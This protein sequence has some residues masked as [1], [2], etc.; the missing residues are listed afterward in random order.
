[1]TTSAI[2]FLY[3]STVQ[4]LMSPGPPRYFVWTPLGLGAGTTLRRLRS[5]VDQA[6]G[7][8]FYVS[9]LQGARRV[10]E[11]VKVFRERSAAAAAGDGAAPPKNFL[12]IEAVNVDFEERCQPLADLTDDDFAHGRLVVSAP[13]P[14]AVELERDHHSLGRADISHADDWSTFWGRYEVLRLDPWRGRWRSRLRRTVRNALDSAFPPGVAPA[15]GENSDVGPLTSDV[16]ES[17]SKVV[18]RLDAWFIAVT[19][20]TGGHPTLLAPAFREL[21]RLLDGV[22]ASDTSGQDIWDLVPE[23]RLNEHE[24]TLLQEMVPVDAV[25]AQLRRNLLHDVAARWMS[26]EIVRLRRGLGK[27]AALLDA[28][29]D[30]TAAGDV[31]L[32]AEVTLLD[33]GFFR[34]GSR[35]LVPAGD[36]VKE[37]IRG[38]RSMVDSAQVPAVRRVRVKELRKAGEDEGVGGWLV[39]VE[40]SRERRFSVPVGQTWTLL[41]KLWEVDGAVSTQALHEAIGGDESDKRRI[42]TA[43]KRLRGWAEDRGIGWLIDKEGRSGHVLIRS[44]MLV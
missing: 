6:G 1:M 29:A 23:E 12:L 2:P 34:Y 7:D 33:S 19:Q 42:Y 9:P 24:L 43:M 40:G 38:T 10:E 3:S 44:H 32:S 30:G 13:L 28:L 31:P 20:I 16:E 41:S 5:G 14:P 17:P 35:G 25:Y 8:A 4:D 15:R 21:H 36:L 39:V 22:R 11:G 26:K 27:Q 18:S 37:L